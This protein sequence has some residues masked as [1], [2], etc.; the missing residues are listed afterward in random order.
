[1]IRNNMIFSNTELAFFSTLPVTIWGMFTT[2][3]VI[4]SELVNADYVRLTM[5][6]EENINLIMVCFLY[7]LIGLTLNRIFEVYE[8]RQSRR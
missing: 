4:F 1:M 2:L 7:G 8:E 6:F 3:V 5:R